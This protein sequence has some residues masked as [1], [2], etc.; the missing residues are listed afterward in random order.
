MS[1]SAQMSL[2]IKCSSCT[3]LIRHHNQRVFILRQKVKKAPK[4]KSIFVWHNSV[5]APVR[6]VVFLCRESPTQLIYVFF[7][8]RTFNNLQQQNAEIK[9]NSDSVFDLTIVRR[10]SHL[11]ED[12]FVEIRHI[13]LTGNWTIVIIPEVLLQSHRVMWDTQDCAQVVR[14]Y[15]KNHKVND[16]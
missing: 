14:Q 13:T 10:F 6:L 4:A 12:V 11:I 3:Y 16:L 7:N 1:Q 2:K 5:T 8:K 15:L 9:K